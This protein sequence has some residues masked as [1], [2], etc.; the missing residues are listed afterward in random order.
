MA[1]A[2]GRCVLQGSDITQWDAV[3]MGAL[4]GV[5]SRGQTQLQWHKQAQAQAVPQ[6]NSVWR[7]STN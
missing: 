1:A 5:P 4:L 3:T 2:Y 6:A 7:T